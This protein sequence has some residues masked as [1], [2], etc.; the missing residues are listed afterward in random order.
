MLPKSHMPK[1]KISN[2]KGQGWL[3]QV[4]ST[5]DLE[6]WWWRSIFRTSKSSECHYC[7]LSWMLHLHFFMLKAT[8]SFSLS[9]KN[10]EKEGMKRT[11]NL[12]LPHRHISASR[13]AKGRF[14]PRSS[15][16]QLCGSLQLWFPGRISSRLVY[17]MEAWSH[18]WFSHP[19]SHSSSPGP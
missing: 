13:T 19:D 5:V 6:G 10:R 11:K 14:P 8:L 7:A 12:S 15:V 1:A 4:K 2:Q 17:L 16:L 18:L 9:M 3:V